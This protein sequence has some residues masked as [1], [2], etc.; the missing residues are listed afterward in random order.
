MGHGYVCVSVCVVYRYTYFAY[1]LC[2][3]THSDKHVN[4][5]RTLT[6]GDKTTPFHIACFCCSCHCCGGFC[7]CCCCRLIEWRQQGGKRTNYNAP[8]P[9]TKIRAV[10][11]DILLCVRI[12]LECKIEIG[13]V[14]WNAIKNANKKYGKNFKRLW[15]VARTWWKCKSN[16]WVIWFIF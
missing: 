2:T 4:Q 8:P 3:H 6:D 5:T 7:C 9:A 15:L 11:T 1:N 16:I 10:K 13:I 14:K 12:S